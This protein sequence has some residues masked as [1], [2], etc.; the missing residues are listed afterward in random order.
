MSSLLILAKKNPL[1]VVCIACDT[2]DII[3]TSAHHISVLG[4][5]LL[6]IY[7]N[8]MIETVVNAAVSGVAVFVDE[9]KVCQVR[10]KDGE[11]RFF[12]ERL[13]PISLVQEKPFD[14]SLEKM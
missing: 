6:L 13:T 9:S 14:V 11:V 5:F 3:H 4:P 2:Q 12:K 1:P 8:S 7:I 10:R